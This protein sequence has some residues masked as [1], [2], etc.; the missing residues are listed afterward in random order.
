MIEVA[1]DGTTPAGP[2][3]IRVTYSGGRAKGS[4][5]TPQ[6]GKIATIAIDTTVPRYAIDDNALQG[7]LPALPLTTGSRHAVQIFS[8]G[9]GTGTEMI[10]TV[11]G[12]ERITVPAGTF[13]TWK[14]EA[15]G[16]PTVAFFVAK[17]PPYQLVRMAVENS[18]LEMVRVR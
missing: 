1:Q 7:L 4:A 14:V 17:A 12:E 2:T 18:P 11:V 9:K 15:R 6:S 3:S 8:S 16:T 5:T 13:E 10:L